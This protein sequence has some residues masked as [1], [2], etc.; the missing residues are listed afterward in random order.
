MGQTVYV[1]MMMEGGKT[2]KQWRPVGVVSDPTV[3][4]QWG[5]YGKE[6][7]WVPLELDDTSYLAPGEQPE[8]RPQKIDPIAERAAETARRLEETN[9][10]LIALVEQMAKRLGFKGKI[11]EL[12][13]LKTKAPKAPKTSSLFDDEE[14]NE[15]TGEV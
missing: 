13:E 7:D 4:E 6:V 1:L 9:Q 12:E 10:R 5:Q 8:F 15:G 3:A 2:T 11:P 14:Y